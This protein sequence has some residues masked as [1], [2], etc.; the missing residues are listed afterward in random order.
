MFHI[1]ISII[2]MADQ[3]GVIDAS[4]ITADS[5]YTFAL[6]KELFGTLF[7]NQNAGS[8]EIHDHEDEEEDEEE[9]YDEE[10]Y[11]EDDEDSTDESNDSNPL[12][13]LDRKAPFHYYYHT[14]LVCEQSFRSPSKLK[15]HIYR[16]DHQIS[17]NLLSG[18]DFLKQPE[19]VSPEPQ[20]GMEEFL[21]PVTKELLI[22]PVVLPCGHMIGLESIREHRATRQGKRCPVCQERI[23][24][25]QT[26]KVCKFVDNHIRDTYGEHFEYI[27][28]HRRWCHMKDLLDRYKKYVQFKHKEIEM[29][30]KV[31]EKKRVRLLVSQKK[32][33]D[34]SNL[35]PDPLE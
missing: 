17:S 22:D 10:D 6:M 14:C 21:D 8:D 16:N 9:D 20:E 26:F 28:N 19:P 23:A 1:N 29:L 25:S 30:E 31:L 2:L 34:L 4:F 27:N 7:T 35:S 24:G 12:E 3:E 18:M 11:W 33:S 32:L 15:K 5:V 13:N